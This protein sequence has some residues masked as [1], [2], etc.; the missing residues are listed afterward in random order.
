MTPVRAQELM[1]DFV[2][3]RQNAALGWPDDSLL[4]EE[5]RN[6]LRMLETERIAGRLQIQG[7]ILRLEDLPEAP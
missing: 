6:Y 3:S 5:D 7:T 1:R 4:H 2:R